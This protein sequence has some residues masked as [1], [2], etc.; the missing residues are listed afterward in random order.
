MSLT[1]V[2]LVGLAIAAGAVT[3]RVTGIG[4]ALT[5]SPLLVLLLGPFAG[6]VLANVFGVAVAVLVLAAT[7]RHVQWRRGLLLMIPAL[8]AI[9]PGAWVARTLPAAWLEIIIGTM[10]LAALALVLARPELSPLRGRGGAATAGAI[11]GFMNVTAGVGGPIM[12]AYAIG[13]RWPQASFAATFQFY[14]IAVNAS[15]VLAKGSPQVAAPAYLAGAVG[16]ACG[17]AAGQLLA[18]HVTSAQARRFVVAIA[19]TGGA[20]TLGRGILHVV[21]G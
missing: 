20:V 17:L 21:T 2:A 11:S 19:V 14:T 16:L 9:V 1:A 10:V 8:V 15:S 4:F 6:V 12:A 5:A 18:R 7:W 13:S 3:Q